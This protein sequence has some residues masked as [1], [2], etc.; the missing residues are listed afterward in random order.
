VKIT[1]HGKADSATREEIRAWAYAT[2]AVLSYHNLPI[3]REVA[4]RVRA[5]W[6]D[7]TAGEWFPDKNEAWVLKTLGKQKLITVVIHELVHS[8]RDFGVEDRCD[9]KCVSTLT[10]RIKKDV[11]RLATVLQRNTYRR[12]AYIAHTK[13]SYRKTSVA[14]CDEYNRE[15]DKKVGWNP[16]ARKIA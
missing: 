14:G 16:K 11:V 6:D 4:I 1:V 9:E 10:A 5:R 15:E 12:A 7:C 3:P 2:G 8:A 13:L